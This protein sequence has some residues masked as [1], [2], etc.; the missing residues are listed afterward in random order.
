[1]NENPY[2]SPSSEEDPGPD[3][4]PETSLTIGLRRVRL[5]TLLGVAACLS[6]Y[7]RFVWR[8][9]AFEGRG[10]WD[11]D[12]GGLGFAITLVGGMAI[13]ALG[14][15]GWFY[16]YPLLRNVSL[17]LRDRFAS[18]V[19]ET[20]WHDSTDRGPWSLPIAAALGAGLWFGYDSVGL[21]GQPWDGVFGTLA[22][23]L[24]GWCCLS[25]M[26]SWHRVRSEVR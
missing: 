17:I 3:L 14:L 1:M 7:V 16:F 8:M 26:M 9:V 25:L 22:Y 18:H 23:A 2:R 19:S 21:Q 13:V 12:L 24:G 20:E 11:D 4:V 15:F 6:T 5:A 10:I